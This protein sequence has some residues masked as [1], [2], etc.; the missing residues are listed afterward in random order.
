MSQ[1]ILFKD[2]GTN[3]SYKEIWD[4]QEAILLRNSQ[5]KAMAKQLT[6]NAD[7]ETCKKET[8]S[9]YLLFVEHNPVYTLGKSGKMSHVLID[10]ADR[11]NKGID[12]YK[13]NRGGDITF[14]GPGQLVG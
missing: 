11:Q 10:E 7:N 1:S 13:I 14:H 4:L 8:T 9:N 5:V 2:L 3:R 12:F 6:D